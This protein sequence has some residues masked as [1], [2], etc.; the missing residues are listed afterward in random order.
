VALVVEEPSQA[1]AALETPHFVH[2]L[3]VA[4]VAMASLGV[5]RAAAVA[6]HLRLVE[7]LQVERL[8]LVGLERQTLLQG[9]L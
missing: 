4:M 2:P 8:V 9:H 3:K 5:D 7:A 1:M 6:V